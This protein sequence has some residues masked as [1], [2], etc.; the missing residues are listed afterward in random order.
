[1]RID[2][3]H[4]PR[5]VDPLGLV[6]TGQLWYLVGAVDGEPR[7]YLVSRITGAELLDE[8]AQRPEGF[9]LAP[10]WQQSVQAFRESLLAS[11]SWRSPRATS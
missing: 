1:M 3:T 10:Y 8:P 2:Y 7:T 9:D 5:V 6:A 4:G 11:T